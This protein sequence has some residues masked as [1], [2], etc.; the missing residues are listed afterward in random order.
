MR[1]TLLF[2]LALGSLLASSTRTQAQTIY[3]AD[4][5]STSLQA[6]SLT[7]GA[8]IWSVTSHDLGYPIAVRGTIWL[9]H[10]DNDG[11]SREYDKATGAFTGNSVTLTGPN[12]QELLDGTTDGAF[13]YSIR[14]FE[15]E[16]YRAGLDWTGS[17]LLFTATGVTGTADGITYDSAANRLWIN[18]SDGLL[19]RYTMTGTEDFSF[20]HVGGRGGIAYDGSNNTLWIV[21]NTPGDPLLQYSTTGTL[22]QSLTANGRSGNVWGAEITF[23]ST[24][25]P[26]PATMGLLAVAGGGMAATLVRRRRRRVVRQ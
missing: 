3:I 13:N 26:E 22:L 18:D 12:Q 4:G 21:P 11:P 16:V 24:A 6:Y 7:T 1:R 14:F 25:V 15:A 10:R 2:L 20:S 5:D 8:Q 17:T 19:R 9:G 23:G